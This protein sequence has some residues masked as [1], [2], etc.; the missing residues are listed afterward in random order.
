L[1]S[2]MTTTLFTS[3]L[4]VRHAEVL[5]ERLSEHG[6]IRGTNLNWYQGV[7]IGPS[8]L[9]TSAG[10]PPKA[11][12][13]KAP[14][15][16]KA[17]QLLAK[18]REQATCLRKRVHARAAAQA[19]ALLEKARRQAKSIRDSVRKT[20]LAR[21]RSFLIKARSQAKARAKKQA[22]EICCQ[23][24]LLARSRG[25]AT[26]ERARARA[27]QQAAIKAGTICAKAC[28]KAEAIIERAVERAEADEALDRARAQRLRALENLR[29]RAAAAPSSQHHTCVQ[30]HAAR[31]SVDNVHSKEPSLAAVVET[32]VP[33][34]AIDVAH[35]QEAHKKRCRTQGI[36][37]NQPR[38]EDNVSVKCSHRSS[39]ETCQSD[40]P[41]EANLEQHEMS[42]DSV[43]G[44]Q[45]RSSSSLSRR[46]VLVGE[47]MDEAMSAGGMYSASNEAPA[48]RKFVH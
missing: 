29:K 35:V 21:A 9:N 37:M 30:E 42:C 24:R 2:S 15:K 28:E 39:T 46:A 13:N 18:A 23:A 41:S 5:M 47:C 16:A 40:K 36:H 6:Q 44:L 31:L 20:A 3:L 1:S 32:L 11:S 26:V 14:G 12:P 4:S 48:K 22:K 34:K 45:R 17:D 10:M 7:H 8:F 38:M 19:K 25:K 43:A 27:K 33:A